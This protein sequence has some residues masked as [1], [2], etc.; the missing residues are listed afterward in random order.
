MAIGTDVIKTTGR[1]I[2]TLQRGEEETTRSIDVPFP[3]TDAE[4]L[5]TAVNEANTRFTS[6]TQAQNLVIQPATWR[7]TNSQEEQWTTVGVS[8][9]IVTT[10]TTPVTPETPATLGSAQEYQDNQEQQG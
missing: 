4:N 3:K 10:T 8:Y 5:Q 1:L 2:F 6:S 9:E 7:D